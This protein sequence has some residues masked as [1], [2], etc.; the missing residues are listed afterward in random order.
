M[1]IDIFSLVFRSFSLGNPSKPVLH[2]RQTL[3]H[4]KSPLLRCC[5]VVHPIRATG[6][7]ARSFWDQEMSLFEALA[8]FRHFPQKRVLQKLPAKR[9]GARVDCPT[10]AQQRAVLEQR[11][12][13]SGQCQND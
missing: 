9:A 11:D 1:H 2:S 13:S 10:A 7:E 4:V 5:G 3:K 8:E 6:L 12:S